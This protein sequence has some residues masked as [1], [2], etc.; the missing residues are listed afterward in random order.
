MAEAPISVDLLQHAVIAA[1]A[2]GVASSSALSI[3][4]RLPSREIP[5]LADRLL[6][7]GVRCQFLGAADT[8]ASGDDFTLAYVFAPPRLSPALT[9]LVSVPTATASFASLATRSFAASRFEREIHDLFGLVPQGHPDRRRRRG[10]P[11]SP[12]RGRGHLRDHRRAGPRRNH[13]AG[14]LPIQRRRR[15]HREPRDATRLRSQGHGE[16]VRG[17][18]PGQGDRPRRADLG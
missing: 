1:G 2:S 10:L 6:T 14:T 5:A 18:T 3:E 13:R 11:V 4:C 12:C 7:L 16:A 9:V 17:A 15:D 8:R